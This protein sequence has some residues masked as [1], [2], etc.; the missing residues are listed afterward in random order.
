MDDGF[1]GE[2]PVWDDD[3]PDEG[4]PFVLEEAEDA[5]LEGDRVVSPGTIRT[6]LAH[7]DFRIMFGG[8]FLSNIGTWMQNV[9]VAALAYDITRSAWFVSLITFANLGPQLLLSVFGGAIADAFDRRKLIIWL[10]L[11]QMI[12]AFLLAWIVTNPDPSRGLLFGAVAFIGIGAALQAPVFL[13]LTPA[14]VPRRDLAGA[15]SLNSVSMNVSRVVGPAIGGV[16][17]ALVGASWVFFGNAITY[18]FIMVAMTRVQVPEV[19]RIEE[20]SGIRKLLGGFTYA[21]REPVVRRAILTVFLFSFFCMSF[22]VEMP[23]LAAVN[24]GIPAKST[25]YGFLYAVFGMGAVAG[26][27]SIGTFLAGKSL[28][29]VVRV[30]LAGFAVCLTAFA[31]LRAA[32]PAFPVGFLLG[33]CYFATV[34]SLATV[35]QAQLPDAMRGRASAVWVMAFGG[36]VPI[37]GL[38]AGWIVSV[39]S[40]TVVVLIGAGMAVFL[41]VYADLRPPEERTPLFGSLRRPASGP[42]GVPAPP[43][44]SP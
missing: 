27:L 17:Y 22:V 29:H 2:E 8:M 35:F 10:S 25:T 34:T 19:E 38:L 40:V 32:A 18:V 26:A 7:R 41:A 12:G 44:D 14:M 33:F 16:L 28:E 31:L 1:R 30:S 37:G 4:H 6:A 13:S 20:E 23:V 21:R 36:T 24:F 42:P 9:V 11:E 43:L 3:G 5:M 15:I 39:T